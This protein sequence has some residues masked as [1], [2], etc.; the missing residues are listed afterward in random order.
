MRETS[1]RA[2]IEAIDPELHLTHVTGSLERTLAVLD[3]PDPGF[4]I[5]TP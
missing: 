5:V 3:E 4:A 1:L 2:V